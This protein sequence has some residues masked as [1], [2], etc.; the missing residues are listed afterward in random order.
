MKGRR[1]LNIHLARSPDCKR[2]VPVSPQSFD[3]HHT[4]LPREVADAVKGPSTSVESLENLCVD[5]PHSHIKR[6]THNSNNGCK[7]CF[8]LS[9][10][11]QFVSSSSHRI[12][13]SVIP[14]NITCDCGSTN[15]IY[16]IT[17]RK[18]RLQYVGETIQPLKDRICKHGSCIK[19]WKGDH[20]CRILTEHFSQGVCKGATYSV[21]I[22]EKLPG[23]GRGEDGKIDSTVA[24]IRRQKERDWMRKLRTVYPFGLNDRTGDEYM[25]DRGN[26]SIF[27]QFP[28]LPRVKPSQKVRTKNPISSSFI[29]DNF[30]YIINESLRTNFRN[31]MNLI[32]VLLSSLKKGHCKILFNSLQDFLSSKHDS[33]R[34]VQYFDAALD[35]IKSKIGKPLESSTSPRSS[36]TNCCH[37]EFD[38]KA[39]DFINLNKIFKDKNI[40]STLPSSLKDD[41]PTVVYKLKDTIRSKV[42][43]YKKFVQSIDVEKLINDS[44]S[45]PCECQS[46]PFIN[47]YHGL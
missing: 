6:K 14:D 9:T 8:S 21:N 46:S 37:I 19:N 33:F 26:D 39:L 31:T 18:C 22:I 35:I 45:L 28:P 43:N 16:L 44:S 41:L 29:V 27:L 3:D 38:N 17:C 23:D 7:L 40:R 47:E 10:K 1:G 24:R 32:R 11:E 25:F 2:N 15:V 34:Y 36:P 4:S 20:G 42:F 30:I 5:S 13:S 12:H